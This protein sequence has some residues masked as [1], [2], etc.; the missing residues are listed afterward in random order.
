M[1]G[2]MACHNIDSSNSPL[3][4]TCEVSTTIN[5]AYIYICMCVCVIYMCVCVCVCYIH[6]CVCVCGQVY[7]A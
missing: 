2:P 5:D 7:L 1:I 6:V 4:K 3:F